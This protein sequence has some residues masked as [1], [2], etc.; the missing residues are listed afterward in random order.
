M[1]IWKECRE[2]PNYLINNFGE[3]KSKERTVR[4]NP[5][6]GVRTVK[7]RV[8][9]QKTKT[10]GYKEVNLYLETNKRKMFYVHRL[11][12]ANFIGPIDDGYEVNHIDGDKSNNFIDNLEIVTASENRKHAHHVLGQKAP[13]YKGQEHPRAKLSRDTVIRIRDDYQNG[14]KPLA[15]SKKYGTP[16]STICKIIYRKTW[17][18]IA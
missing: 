11:V 10:N 8:L 14:M 15:L 12:V 4:N 16:K 6:R 1:K 5:S 3:V 2:A 13:C 17:R 7:S 9:S 18:H